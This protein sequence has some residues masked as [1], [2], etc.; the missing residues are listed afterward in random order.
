MSEENKATAVAREEEPPYAFRW[1]S[2]QPAMAR[3]RRHMLDHDDVL[4]L[5][6][7]QRETLATLQLHTPG[8]RRE[9]L[10]KYRDIQADVAWKIHSEEPP[11]TVAQEDRTS[12]SILRADRITVTDGRAPQP[13]TDLERILRKP[14]SLDSDR[15]LRRA[16]RLLGFFN[17]HWCHEG[18]CP[19][20]CVNLHRQQH[21]TEQPTPGRP[22]DEAERSYD[23]LPDLVAASDD[24]E[25]E[26][27]VSSDDDD[28]PRPIPATDTAGPHPVYD[29]DDDIPELHTGT[30]DS[31]PDSSEDMQQEPHRPPPPSI[32]PEY[33]PVVAALL[34]SSLRSMYNG[35]LGSDDNIDYLLRHFLDEFDPALHTKQDLFLHLLAALDAHFIASQ[36]L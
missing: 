4:R 28:D 5:I 13:A 9:H 29:S 14:I 11:P 33:Y 20:G 25:P 34:R 1:T 3:L 32:G 17:R 15:D 19:C 6:T 36:H 35:E 26:P 2:Y 18:N 30:D 22:D 27:F 31:D 7:T 21:H 8:A 10:D 16:I 12:Y 23:D 24:E